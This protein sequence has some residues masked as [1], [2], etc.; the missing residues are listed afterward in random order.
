MIEHNIKATGWRYKFV[1]RAHVGNRSNY[2]S[3]GFATRSVYCF[4]ISPGRHARYRKSPA[5]SI[6]HSVGSPC[7]A[8][9]DAFLAFIMN[10]EEGRL[11][12][13]SPAE[14]DSR[15]VRRVTKLSLRHATGRFTMAKI[16][17]YTRLYRTAFNTGNVNVFRVK[18][19]A[20][21]RKLILSERT[22]INRR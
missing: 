14:K 16:N 3:A 13:I 21:T 2:N 1:R 19:P 7:N 12:L 10:F 9:N 20:V 17:D 22:L 5:V 8:C 15:A 11:A 6:D 18:Q 4:E